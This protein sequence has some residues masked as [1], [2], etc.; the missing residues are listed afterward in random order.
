[1]TTLQLINFIASRPH[2]QFVALLDSD[3]LT[4]MQA[5]EQLS[6]EVF[7]NIWRVNMSLEKGVLICNNY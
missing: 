6:S 2:I 1:M 4:P 7:D 5:I 3:D